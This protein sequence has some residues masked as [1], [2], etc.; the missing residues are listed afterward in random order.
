MLDI[1]YLL[2]SLE[3]T[4]LNQQIGN[5]TLTEYAGIILLKN[6][7][8]LLESYL[9]VGYYADGL[10]HLASCPKDQ[11]VTMFLSCEDVNNCELPNCGRHNVVLSS[12][13]VFD[14]YN[15]IN[16]IIQN[17]HYWSQSLQQSL[18]QGLPLPEIIH[19]ASSLLHSPLFILNPGYR[20]LT[21]DS[22]IPCQDIY[23]QELT[24]NGYL[25]QEHLAELKANVI[26]KDSNRYYQH[27]VLN[28]Y[29]YHLFRIQHQRHVLAHIFL[30]VYA[31]EN[32]IDY[33]HLL[34][35]LSITVTRFL[36]ADQEHILDQ[37]AV[38]AS[39]FQ[40]VIEEHFTGIGELTDRL[41]QL[42]YPVKVFHAF[43]LIRFDDPEQIPLYGPIFRQLQSI[44]P[45]TNMAMYQKD[46]LI[47][48][49]QQ[50]RPNGL[51]D[52]HYDKLR[53]FLVQFHA[54]AGISNASRHLSR[55][56]TL[57]ETAQS[58]LR[59]GLK[60]P[61]FSA[62]ERYFNYED[63]SMYYI[64]DLAAR[65]FITDHHN[66]DLIYLIHPIVIT[67][68]RYDATHNTNLRDV[69]FYYLL[70]GCS[71]NRTAQTMYMHRNTV[72][73]K[74]N[75]INEITEIPL[76][77]GYTQHRMIMSCLIIRYYENYMNHVVR[78]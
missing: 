52:F 44:F 74:L 73:N 76:E 65:Q 43:I 21:G 69:L 64:I 63:Y 2:K 59:L 58:T 62:D 3:R 12:L 56:R 35:D 10:R 11:S 41:N 30:C 5:P 18:C 54:H 71:V 27:C 72:L 17:Y 34:E 40:D 75:K 4:I 46:I 13:D 31:Q 8:K 60:L 29:H 48:H 47:L 20:N 32:P 67:I 15:R 28:G 38:C 70:C 77:D 7:S 36:A 9:Y 39:F 53:D 37:D 42:P 78:L 19:Q 55:F 57:W 24:R 23:C 45:E 16:R 49:S 51:L 6:Q 1:M 25:S 22:N 50:N 61:R 66:D 68:C 26:P 14:I 33:R